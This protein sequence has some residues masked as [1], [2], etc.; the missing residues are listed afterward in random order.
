MS[1]LRALQNYCSFLL[2]YPALEA[3][4][5]S[6]SWP[7]PNPAFVK[8]L[9]YHAF[10]QK[11]GPD[12][13]YSS[14]SFGCVRNHGQKFHEGLDLFPLNSDPS[15]K[16][17]DSVF[18]AMPGTIAYLN[19]TAKD[20]AYG[21][22]VVLEHPDYK[23]T[24]YTLYAHLE[25]ISPGLSIG[26][27]VKAAEPIGKMGNSASFHIPLNRSHLHFEIGIRLSA[28]FDRWYDRQPFKTPNKHGNYNGYNLVGLDPLQFYSAYLDQGFHSPEEFIRS[29]PVLVKL[30][31]SS[32][33]IPDL[34]KENPSLCVNGYPKE[35]FSSWI[36][37]FGPFGIPLSFL[38]SSETAA[39]AVEIISF[40]PMSEEQPCRSLIRRKENGV[41]LAE[42]LQ[43][44][45]EIIFCN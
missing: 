34:V 11:T 22:Y 32:Q 43:T 31:V 6:L 7:T 17:K 24:L 28:N 41:E 38:P 36:C 4:S 45:L 18:A 29:L 10:L 26:T 42:Q 9:G 25:D 8:G 14:G 35:R 27:P 15:G 37:C 30:R 1:L 2:L 13:E 12:K 23:P 16:A 44:Y 21:K 19:K 5:L 33:I 39:S 40:E 20:S 3:S